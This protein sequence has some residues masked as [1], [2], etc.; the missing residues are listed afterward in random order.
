MV[1]HFLLNLLNELRKNETIARLAG[2]LI[3]FLQR[4]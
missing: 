3:A 1:V 4:V 2:H